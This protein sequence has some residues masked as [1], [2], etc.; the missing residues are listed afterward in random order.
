M[1]AVSVLKN[2]LCLNRNQIHVDKIEGKVVEV[3][4]KGIKGKIQD[5]ADIEAHRAVGGD[6]FSTRDIC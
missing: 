6:V 5:M 4:E 3:L 1:T 2:V